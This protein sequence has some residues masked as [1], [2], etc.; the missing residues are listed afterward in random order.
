MPHVSVA[1]IQRSFLFEESAIFCPGTIKK[2]LALSP[3]IFSS[4]ESSFSFDTH[5][6]QDPL[7]N[8]CDNSRSG[9]NF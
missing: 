1:H 4:V 6:V 2:I 7:E 9:H 3:Q 5:N 8:Y